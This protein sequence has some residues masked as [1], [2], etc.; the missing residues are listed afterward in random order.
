MSLA[1]LFLLLYKSLINHKSLQLPKQ[2]WLNLAQLAVF[3]IY[4]PYVLRYWAI[5]Y[6]SVSS[7]ALFFNLTPLFCYL[8]A[9]SLGLQKQSLRRGIGLIISVTGLLPMII[10]NQ[11][12]TGSCQ[13]ITSNWFL[14]ELAMLGAVLSLSYGWIVMQKTVQQ[15]ASPVIA[16]GVSMLL[17]G[18]LS[19]GTSLIVGENMTI[20]D[21]Y[22]LFGWLSFIIIVT[23]FICYN[24]QAILLKYFNATTVSLASLA[25]P[26]FATIT[27]IILLGETI[28][29]SFYISASLLALGIYIF[30]QA[31]KLDTAMIAEEL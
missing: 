22:K 27:S 29:W 12:A 3:N 28:H 24:A 8:I 30:Y 15:N 26:L 9:Y 31:D 16:N 13:S 10:C 14:P 1:G 11:T 17:G 4:L 7:T 6:L 2:S 21:P 5:Q 19:L 20:T 25:A 18:F 23:N